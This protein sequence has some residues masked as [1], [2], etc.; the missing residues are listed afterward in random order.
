M[1]RKHGVPLSLAFVCVTL[2]LSRT[3]LSHSVPFVRT[4]ISL[5]VKY[6]R[7]SSLNF[8]PDLDLVSMI[9]H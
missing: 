8:C 3:L 7:L 9:L 2:K 6:S 5:S 4:V 1:V